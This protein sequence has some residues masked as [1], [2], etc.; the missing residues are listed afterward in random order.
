MIDTAIF[1][2]KTS[3]LN[4]DP[5][6]YKNI[7]SYWL[8]YIFIVLQYIITTAVFSFFLLETTN[9]FRPLICHTVKRCSS[10]YPTEY[11]H[12]YLLSE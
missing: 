5:W 4:S 11:V 1:F 7:Y 12:N 9:R 3:M 10:Y 6:W 8:S 2:T